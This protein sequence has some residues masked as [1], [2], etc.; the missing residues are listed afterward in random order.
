MIVIFGGDVAMKAMRGTSEKEYV[1][2][3]FLSLMASLITSLH[4]VSSMGLIAKLYFIPT[5]TL[6]SIFGKKIVVSF[7]SFLSF[8]LFPF[9]KFVYS[10]SYSLILVFWV[11]VYLLIEIFPFNF[12]VQ[13]LTFLFLFVKKFFFFFFFLHFFFIFFLH[14]FFD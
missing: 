2:G 7:F 9:F 1:Y 5:V 3:W 4:M 11:L 6:P 14:F 8:F 12:P 10:Y 13:H